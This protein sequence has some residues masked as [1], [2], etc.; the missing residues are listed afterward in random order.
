MEEK[1]VKKY[2]RCHTC[3][4]L[5]SENFIKEN[6][7]ITCEHIIF[8]NCRYE[9]CGMEFYTADYNCFIKEE[10]SDFFKKYLPA[11]HWA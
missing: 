4:S 5:T 11:R 6:G 7:K 1:K 3:G 2:F 10:N 9:F 8:R